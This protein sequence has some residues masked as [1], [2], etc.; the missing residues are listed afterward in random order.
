MFRR[1]SDRNLASVGRYGGAQ[2]TRETRLARNE[3][4]FREVNERIKD[5][6]LAQTD[7]DSTYEFLCECSNVDCDLRLS[8]PLSTY[9]QARAGL[10]ARCRSRG[11]A[12]LKLRTPFVLDGL[13]LARGCGCRCGF[14]GGPERR[15][16]RVLVPVAAGDGVLELAY[17]L[18]E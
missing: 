2:W 7:E 4:L 9:E 12:C 17:F 10:V 5:L 18:S 1:S 6:A 14:V 11:G 13:A 16:L 3:T 8:L 15:L